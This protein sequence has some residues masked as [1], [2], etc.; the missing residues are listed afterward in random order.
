MRGDAV[1]TAGQAPVSAVD[2][3]SDE[4][5]AD[6]FR[7]HGE[8]REAGPV[9]WLERYGIWAMARYAE[10]HEALR[11]WATYCSAAG[12]G[13]S[14]FRK[15]KPWRPPSLLLEAD[16]PEHD[17]ARKAVARA[18]S[19]R[20]IRELRERLRPGGGPAGRRAGQPGHGGR[21]DRHRRGVPAAG[22]RRRG[23][24][25]RAGRRAAAGLREHGVQRVRAAQRADHAVAAPGR[26]G[27]RVDRRPL[28]PGRARPGRPGRAHLRQ[29]GRRHDHRG[30]GGAAG[31]VAAHRGRG[32][33]RD[34]A[35]LRAGLPG[36][37]PGAVAAAPR[38]TRRWP[39]RRS[40]SRCGTPRR[41]RRSSAPPPGR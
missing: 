30:G 40:R 34:R 27:R 18:L 1:T 10:V 22:V 7:W 19:P 32:H 28:P 16:P 26:R 4:F 21:R 25:A 33:H 24:P 17:R 6:P 39:G 31:P 23:R 38:P 12:V 36:P 41:C 3:F 11:D 2:P 13:L 5:L 20:T 14:D 15:E 35:R 37:R 29:R 9:V 8:L